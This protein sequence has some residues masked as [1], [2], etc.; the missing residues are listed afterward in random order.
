L[1]SAACGAFSGAV[2]V[3]LWQ[4]IDVVKS[5]M[6]G[7]NSDKYSS[8]F[9]CASQILRQEGFLAFYKGIGPRLMRVCIEVAMTMSLFTEISKLLDK[10]WKTK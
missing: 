8:T 2:S 9:D 6:Q 4:G 5:R 3:L 7:L 10:Y 1:Q